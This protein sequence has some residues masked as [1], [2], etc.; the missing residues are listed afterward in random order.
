MSVTS[1]HINMQNH[2]LLYVSIKKV[3]LEWDIISM[4]WLVVIDFVVVAITAVTFHDVGQVSLK[5][6]TE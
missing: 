2:I 6:C 5:P 3:F 4:K 1:S